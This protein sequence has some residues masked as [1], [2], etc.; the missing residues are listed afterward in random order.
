MSYARERSFK[1][2]VA[3]RFYN[4][5]YDGIRELIKD[6]PRELDLKLF[7]VQ[8]IDEIELY[9][10]RV[11]FVDVHDQPG[12]GIFAVMK[13]TPELMDEYVES[14]EVHPGKEVRISCK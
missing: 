7:R 8:D 5:L 2:Y 14:V 6:N 4:E 3:D 13:L 1:E 11:V 12:T 9:D 10:I